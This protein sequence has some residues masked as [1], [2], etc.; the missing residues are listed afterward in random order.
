MI[1]L[2]ELFEIIMIVFLRDILRIVLEMLI[3]R[4]FRRL[5]TLPFQLYFQIRSP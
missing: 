3:L 5:P 2:N 1:D 4:E